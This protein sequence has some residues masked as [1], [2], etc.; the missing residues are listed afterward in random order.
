MGAALFSTKAIF[1]KLAYQEQ[2]SATLMLAWR[3]IFALPFFAGVG[4]WALMQKRRRGEAAP[5]ARD[6]GLTMGC[7]A[8]GYYVASYFD[9]AG[10][11][12]ISA[13]LERLLLFTYPIMIM[14]L[15]AAL[16]GERITRTQLIAAAI[17]YAG[18]GLAFLSAVPAG[19][20]ETIAGTLFVLG[21]ALAFAVHQIFAKRF[22]ASLGA[23][24]YTAISMSAA[25][26]CCIVHHALV[27]GANFAAT[28]RFLWMAAGCAL[29]ATV[30]PALAINASLAR[31]TPAGVAMISTLS[32]IVTIALAVVILSE[33]FT[34][35]D[36]IGAAL[37]IA[38]VAL[39]TRGDTRKT[40]VPEASEITP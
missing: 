17:T 37:V 11:Q 26:L 30:L 3:M 16:F 5:T 1:I 6:V 4:A 20:R 25:A 21:A 9:F 35:A 7:G 19:G 38:G 34:L 10:L 36:A 22:I 29:F 14:F 27:S 2:V 23:M 33:P 13:Q 15:S 28:P 40:T 39:Y 31:I 32:P 8:L 18:L 12:Y 24:L